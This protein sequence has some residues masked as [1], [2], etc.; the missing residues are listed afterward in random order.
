MPSCWNPD[1]EHPLKGVHDTPPHV[2]QPVNGVCTAPNTTRI[3]KLELQL[4]YPQTFGPGI[5]LS[6]G[7]HYTYHADFWNA[8]N[9]QSELD[10][11]VV[12]C[13]N[14]HLDCGAGG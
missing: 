7:P 13:L 4:H 5:T 2:R 9:P 8:W 14:G 11:L 10:R 12:T 6:S 3:P 1:S